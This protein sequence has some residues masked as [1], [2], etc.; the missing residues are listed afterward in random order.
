M[1]HRHVDNQFGRCLLRAEHVRRTP[2]QP[3]PPL[4]DD[5]GMHVIL[6][7]NLGQRLLDFHSSQSHLGFKRRAV[8]PAES[9]TYIASYSRPTWPLSDRQSTYPRCADFP[10]HLSKHC[11]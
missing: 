6:L 10:S 8:V 9:L 1:Q 5:V 11:H 7:R 3:Q 2:Q 4:V